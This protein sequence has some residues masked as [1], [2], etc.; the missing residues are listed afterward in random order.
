MENTEP[1]KRQ[2]AA[3]RSRGSA[4]GNIGDIQG[5]DFSSDS[6]TYKISNFFKRGDPELEMLWKML[7]A[8]K[9]TVWEGLSQV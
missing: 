5:Q 8:Q 6:P 1:W 9:T 4:L 2:T 7:P 3:K